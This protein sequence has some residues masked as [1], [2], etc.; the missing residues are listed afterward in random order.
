MRATLISSS[1][2]IHSQPSVEAPGQ[3][4]EQRWSICEKWCAHSALINK[5]VYTSHKA[6][7]I[8]DKFPECL[9]SKALTK[10]SLHWSQR[11]EQN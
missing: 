7:C 6:V 2:L 4:M 8:N 11:L 5:T 3:N 9:S 1:K 10:I